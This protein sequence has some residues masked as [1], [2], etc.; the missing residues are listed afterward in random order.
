VWFLA[1]EELGQEDQDERR[2]ETLAAKMRSSRAHTP[3]LALRERLPAEW[4]PGRE[5]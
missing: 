1:R 3:S 2:V 5:P 4:D